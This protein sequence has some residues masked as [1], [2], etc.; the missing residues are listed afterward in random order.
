MYTPIA[1]AV[2]ARVRPNDDRDGG[3][4][5]NVKRQRSRKIEPGNERTFGNHVVLRGSE[6]P[7]VAHAARRPARDAVVVISELHVELTAVPEIT[8][9]RPR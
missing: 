7:G 3:P 6:G 2:A 9:H 8:A 5:L 4:R 1:V